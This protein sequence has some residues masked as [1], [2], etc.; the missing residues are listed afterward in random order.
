V[1]Q[2]L[3]PGGFSQA[4]VGIS[5]TIGGVAHAT[6]NPTGCHVVFFNRRLWVAFLADRVGNEF[7][8]R[9]AN[10]GAEEGDQRGAWSRRLSPGFDNVRLLPGMAL[11]VRPFA[12]LLSDLFDNGRIDGRYSCAAVHSAIN[13]VP[14]DSYG[15]ATDALRRYQRSVC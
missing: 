3:V 5:D 1:S 15:S 11:E 8:F 6:V 2:A 12:L 13:H 7:R 4:G 9:P 10:P 14:S